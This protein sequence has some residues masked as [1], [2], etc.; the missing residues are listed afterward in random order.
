MGIIK[1]NVMGLD[2]NITLG[3][4]REIVVLVKVVFS[5]K[6]VVRKLKLGFIANLSG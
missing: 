1:K 2:K 5:V 4:K 3:C 6:K